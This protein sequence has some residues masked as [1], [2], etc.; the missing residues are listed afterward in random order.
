MGE[1]IGVDFGAKDGDTTK[2]HLSGSAFCTGCRHE[3]VAVAEAGTKVL[4]CPKCRRDFG[5]YKSPV[6]PKAK[7][8]CDCGEM[9]FWLTPDGALCRGCGAIPEG[10]VE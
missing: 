6:E 9:L 1:V 8:Q 2:R 3:W 10:W 4:E 7:W 5:L